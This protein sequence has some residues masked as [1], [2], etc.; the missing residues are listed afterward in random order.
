M[1][2]EIIYARTQVLY[3]RSEIQYAHT[4][5]L[6]AGPKIIYSGLFD[7]SLRRNVLSQSAKTLY[8]GGIELSVGGYFPIY[9][10]ILFI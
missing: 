7:V 3:A 9:F 5:V 8:W 10:L 4:E 6:Y 1:R 2:T